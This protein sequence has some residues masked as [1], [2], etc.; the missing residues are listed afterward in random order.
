VRLPTDI[1]RERFQSIV[2]VSLVLFVETAWAAALVYLS[3]HFL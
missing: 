2:F 3:L 1:P